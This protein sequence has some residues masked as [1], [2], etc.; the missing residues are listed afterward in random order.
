KAAAGGGGRGMRVV[1]DAAELEGAVASVMSEA[2]TAF[3]NPA[4]YIEKYLTDIRHIEVQVLCDGSSAVH[5]G[6]RDCTAQRRNQKLVEE[7]PSPIL[8]GDTRRA[9][10]ESALKLCRQ[11]NYRNAGTVEYVFDNTS[12]EFYFIEMNTRVQVEHPVTEMVTGI[13]IIKAQL[14][15]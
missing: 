2:E 15:I 6:E 9:L 4:V 8:D 7:A 1:R 3:G 11:V 10:C 14:R 12:G 13:D 5:L